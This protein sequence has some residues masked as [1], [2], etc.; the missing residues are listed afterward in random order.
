MLP[1][2]VALSVPIGRDFGY[3]SRITGK[4]FH[5]GHVYVEPTLTGSI[6]LTEYLDINLSGHVMKGLCCGAEGSTL[7]AY[8][9]EAG[10]GVHHASI[11]WRATAGLT[12]PFGPT[13]G[14]TVAVRLGG[15]SAD[16]IGMLSQGSK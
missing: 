4:V 11:S 14:S 3:T 10:L 6:P 12:S 15:R 8:G 7:S 16:K 13:I 5:R 2:R 9:F 1:N